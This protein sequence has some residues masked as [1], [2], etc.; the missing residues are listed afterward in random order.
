MRALQIAALVAILINGLTP[1]ASAS[2]VHKEKRYGEPR[3]DKALVYVIR[4]KAFVGGGVGI[5]V[6]ADEQ[7]IAFVRNNSYGFGYVEPGSRLLWGDTPRSL[8]VQLVAGETYYVE[9]R[10]V[11]PISLLTEGQG[12]KAIESVGAFI[13]SDQKDLD[14]AARKVAKRYDKVQSREARQEK[15]SIEEVAAPDT[16]PAE[17]KFRLAPNTRITIELM[18]NISSSLSV[19]G[20]TV[21]FRV[22]DEVDADTRV[23][24]PNGSRVKATVR[25]ARAGASF[26]EQGT[27][28]I[29]LV[30]VDL[31][32]QM[33]IPLLGGLAVAGEQ[34]TAGM[35]TGLVAGAF[36]KGTEAFHAAGTRFSAWTRDEVWLDATSETVAAVCHTGVIGPQ[37][38]FVFGGNTRREP[39]PVE[40]PFP[41]SGEVSDV[42]IV[43]VGDWRLAEPVKAMSV[44]RAND[45]CTARFAGWSVLR[46]VRL[47]DTAQPLHLHAR[48]GTAE[49]HVDVPARIADGV[50]E[51]EN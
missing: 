6:F 7:L 16:A 39:P 15:A 27:L 40:L 43:S 47:S 32:D 51:R 8:E 36:I 49:V 44:S 34:R 28:D 35:M 17:G 31:D 26:G 9:A 33:R 46:H 38:D 5:F 42:H 4:E 13:E 24:I 10:P 20:E 22:A 14:T 19:M 41:C 1:A 18:E 37:R 23:L 21:W 30:S 2:T 12:K 11:N 50:K 25:Q 3:P 45:I 29:A 48:S